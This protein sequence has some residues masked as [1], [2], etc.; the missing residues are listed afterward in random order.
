MCGIIGYTGKGNAGKIMLDALELLEYRGYDSAGIA[1][2]DG[3]KTQIVK[4]AGRVKELRGLYEE[5]KPAGQCGIGHT[6]WATHGGVSNENAHPH[7][8]GKITLIHNGIIENYK[9]LT[10]KYGLEGS[11]ASETDSEVVAAVLEH[12]YTGDPYSAIR[13]TVLKLKGTFALAILFED[14]P[15]KI[16]AVRNVSPIVAAVTEKGAM[17]S[18]DVAAIVPFTTDYFVVPEFHVICLSPQGIDMFDLSGDRAEVEWLKVDWDV[19]RSGKGGYPFYMEKEIMEQP[20]VIAE[21]ILPRIKDGKPDFSEEGIPDQILKDCKRICVIACGTAMHAGLVGKSLIQAMIGI[22]VDVVMASEF[23]YNDPVVNKDTLVI[24]ISQSGE[25]IDTLEALKFARKCGSPS[26]SVV[27][28]KGASIARASEYV[29]YTNA[30]PEIAV[31]STKAYTTQLAVLY[32]ITARMAMA[33]GLWEEERLLSFM[34]E[35]QRVPQVMAKVLDTKEEIHRLAGVI[36][37]AQDVFMIG[38]GLDYSILLEGSLKLKEVSYI[39]S[40]AY[41][42]GELKHGTIALITEDTPVVAVVTQDKL[43]S[44][45]ISNIREVQSRGARV[46][47][48]IK[49]NE[50]LDEGEQWSCVYRLPKMDDPFMVMPASIVLQLIAYFVSLDKG[51]DVDK[52]R[53]LAKVVTVE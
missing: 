31:A 50:T 5:L 46:V 4:R 19:S 27:N 13:R 38:R 34:N 22:H 14:Q 29:I 53:N 39:H 44:K 6:R 41:A 16:F 7:K 12:F 9:E 42:S 51:L 25:T 3:G 37:N 24:A 35:L 33:R 45:E 20:Q 52:P 47:L 32:L 49:E 48:L 21:T 8:F 11:L 36:L 30:G 26:I 43:K 28:V 15:D 17:L 40:E 18:S 2:L 1:L 10:E 23:M